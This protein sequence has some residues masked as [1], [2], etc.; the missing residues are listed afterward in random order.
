MM[1]FLEEPKCFGFFKD[2]RTG[3]FKLKF[4]QLIYLHKDQTLRDDRT[5]SFDIK[6]LEDDASLVGLALLNGDDS[7]AV[8]DGARVARQ[9]SAVVTR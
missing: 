4:L 9:L 6:S 7:R 5:W 1:P 3:Y 2:D 8:L